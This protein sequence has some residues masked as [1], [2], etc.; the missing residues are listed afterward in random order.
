MRRGLK[1]LW[2]TLERGQNI[3]RL[4]FKLLKIVCD[5]PRKAIATKRQQYF[6]SCDFLDHI[7][8]LHPLLQYYIQ[9][10]I[11]MIY[12]EVFRINLLGLSF[13]IFSTVSFCIVRLVYCH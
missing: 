9:F 5:S 12:I 6:Y 8:F 10:I 4:Y 1:I 11:H 13:S 2:A 7:Y 3:V